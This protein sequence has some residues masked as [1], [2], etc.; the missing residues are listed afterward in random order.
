VLFGA[1]GGGVAAVERQRVNCAI[2]GRRIILGF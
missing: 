2:R 1:G